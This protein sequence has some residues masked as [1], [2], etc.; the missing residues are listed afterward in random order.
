MR[1]TAAPDAS[2]M[3]DAAAPTGKSPKPKM[4][5]KVPQR[6]GLAKMTKELAKRFGG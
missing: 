5:R 3:P 4:M 6:D 2:S 1:S